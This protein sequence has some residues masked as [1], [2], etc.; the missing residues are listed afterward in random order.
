MPFDFYARTFIHRDVHTR[1]FWCSRSSASAAV[2]RQ[3]SVD[4]RYLVLSAAVSEVHSV[5]LWTKNV[6]C[7]RNAWCYELH[8]L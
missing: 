8:R 6:Q 3:A 4:S 5:L 1:K 7:E 2:Q